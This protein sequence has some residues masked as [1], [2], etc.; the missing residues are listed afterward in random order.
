MGPLNDSS[1]QISIQK[2][3]PIHL[4]TNKAPTQITAYLMQYYLELSLL[5]YLAQHGSIIIAS[6]FYS[7]ICFPI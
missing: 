2:H 5:F 4:T 7:F 3:T 6:L 1:D